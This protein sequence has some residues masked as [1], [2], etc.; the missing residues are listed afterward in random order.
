MSKILTDKA[1]APIGP[2]SQ[3]IL[4]QGAGKTLYCSGAIPVDPVSGEIPAG[5]EAQTELALKNL[6]A[7]IN[8]AG[9]DPTDVV[10]TT[11]FLTD[12]GDFAA[13]NG[14]YA[15]YLSGGAATGAPARSCVAVAALP[16]GVSV[17]I[18]AIA[19]RSGQ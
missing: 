12:M 9:F 5:I 19:F 8:E 16:K 11:C 2:Y 10:K 17:E 7:V 6:L 18:E 13:F 4:T 1:P 3:G 15:K 14:I